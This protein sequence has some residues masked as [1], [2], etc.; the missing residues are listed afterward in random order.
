M[1]SI[2]ACYVSTYICIYMNIHTQDYMAGL[3]LGIRLNF[4]FYFVENQN[5]KYFSKS[6]KDNRDGYGEP[7]SE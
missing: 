3:C 7:R 2:Y 4:P 5:C 1:I 6:L